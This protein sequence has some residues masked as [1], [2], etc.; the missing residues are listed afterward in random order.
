MTEIIIACIL[1]LISALAFVMSLRSFRG[2]GFLFNNAY[3]YASE[4]EREAM[5]KTPYYRQSAIIFLLVGIVFLLNGIE[6]LLHFD[7]IVYIVI[8]VIIGAIIYAI[9]SSVVIN[10]HH[11]QP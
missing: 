10:K 5:D 1:F 4:Q 6:L 7:R 3:L 9:I 8:A 11:K 2:Q